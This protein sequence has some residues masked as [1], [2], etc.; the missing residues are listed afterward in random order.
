MLKLIEATNLV[1]Q[2]IERTAGKPFK[3]IRLDHKLN[4]V[5]IRDAAALK[6]LRDEI[7]NGPEGVGSRGHRLPADAL[8]SIKV[9]TTVADV[10]REVFAKAT[11][12]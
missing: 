7:R 9:Q 3:D 6:I 5:R 4:A 10:R 2:C 11:P 8:R 1:K 12:V